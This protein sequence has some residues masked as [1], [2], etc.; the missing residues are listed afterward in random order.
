ML[1]LVGALSN[2]LLSGIGIKVADGKVASLG[3]NELRVIP[4]F[5]EGKRA[6]RIRRNAFS[7][8]NNRFASQGAPW[9]FVASNTS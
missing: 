8:P 2:Q 3:C 9:T 4:L 1:G 6:A 5:L 7:D